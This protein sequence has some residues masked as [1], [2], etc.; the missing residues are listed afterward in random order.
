[1]NLS[2]TDNPLIIEIIFG[3]AFTTIGM[4]FLLR[5]KKVV[6]ASVLSSKVF[7]EKVGLGFLHNDRWAFFTTSLMIPFMGIIF[8]LVGLMLTYN[9]IYRITIIIKN[10]FIR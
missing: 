10:L 1:M 6:E 5:R 3:I 8:S 2:G 4:F 9:A 7:W